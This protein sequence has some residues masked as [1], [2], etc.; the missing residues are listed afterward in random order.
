[1]S[2]TRKLEELQASLRAQKSAID[3][4][5][6]AVETTLKLLR[7]FQTE[8]GGKQEALVVNPEEL[9]GL[10]QPNAIRLIAYKNNG[11]IT[12][13]GVRPLLEKAGVLRKTKNW[14]NVIYGV[15]NKSG[16]FEHIGPGKYKLKSLG[17]F[18]LFVSEPDEP[19][20]H[21]IHRIEARAARGAIGPSP[22]VERAITG[23]S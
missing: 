9:K 13:K 7:K 2:D 19:K 5:L 3:E 15:I 22:T 20:S 8:P 18:D 1:M 11:I 4:Q 17:G 10:T 23:K 6:T 21:N 12:I 14:Y 16:Q